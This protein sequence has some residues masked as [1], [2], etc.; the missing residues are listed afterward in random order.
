MRMSREDSG[1]QAGRPQRHDGTRPPPTASAEVAR[2]RARF[3]RDG[4]RRRGGA[5]RLRG[6]GPCPLGLFPR[7]A[8]TAVL[9]S[10]T[11]TPPPS[12]GA[13]SPPCV[14]VAIR[15]RLVRGDVLKRGA[16]APTGVPSTSVFPLD[17]PYAADPAGDLRPPQPPPGDASALARDLVV[18]LRTRRLRRRCRGGAGRIVDLRNSLRRHFGDTTLD[19]FRSVCA[20]E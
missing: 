2:K 12:S 14:W 6:S 11:G 7:H 20:T 15:A 13:T 4:T 16:A 19:L 17:P 3:L 10:A 5:G 9:C 8:D 1:P 18:Q